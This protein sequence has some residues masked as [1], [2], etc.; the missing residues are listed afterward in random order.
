MRHSSLGK[1]YDW[2][3]IRE[4][5]KRRLPQEMSESEKEKKIEKVYADYVRSGMVPSPVFDVLDCNIEPDYF[6]NDDYVKQLLNNSKRLGKNNK[7]F[8]Q[9]TP[10]VIQQMVS[11]IPM[12]RVDKPKLILVFN[13]TMSPSKWFE[14]YQT[15]TMD[16]ILKKAGI[17]PLEH[18]YINNYDFVKDYYYDA[19]QP[20]A[21]KYINE[22]KKKLQNETW[23][24]YQKFGE[25]NF[26]NIKTYHDIPI[27]NFIKVSYYYRGLLLKRALENRSNIVYEYTHR[28][29]YNLTCLL[30]NNKA[31]LKEYEVEMYFSNWNLEQHKKWMI[32][33]LKQHNI[34]ENPR[35]ITGQ[36][37][38]LLNN[39]VYALD[40][41]STYNMKVGFIDLNT[42]IVSNDPHQVYGEGAISSVV[43]FYFKEL[44][45][46]I[47]P[48]PYSFK[49]DK[50][51]EENLKN[52]HMV[53]NFTLP[54]KYEGS[55]HP[56][57]H[58]FSERMQIASGPDEF[59]K[60]TAESFLN[61]TFNRFISQVKA[62]PVQN[63]K[64]IMLYGPPGV[65][66]SYTIDKFME[67]FGGNCVFIPKDEI[68]EESK[69]YTIELMNA[70]D[71]IYKYKD[72]M[73]QYLGQA[74]AHM[75]LD[76]AYMKIVNSIFRKYYAVIN[77]FY[78]MVI[79]WASK[80]NLNIIIEATGNNY[81]HLTSVFK[82]ASIALYKKEVYA[83]HVNYWENYMNTL[84]RIIKEPIVKLYFQPGTYVGRSRYF[85]RKELLEYNNNSFKNLQRFMT[86]YR[87][88]DIVLADNTDKNIVEIFRR[89][90]GNFTCVNK[91]QE[92]MYTYEEESFIEL[93]KYCGLHGAGYEFSSNWT[94]IIVLFAFI[95]LTY[96][97]VQF[98]ME[99]FIASNNGNFLSGARSVRLMFI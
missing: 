81:E 50:T 85:R 31:I 97:F 20:N 83:I 79:E 7:S 15:N 67:S 70:F 3:E 35:L 45:K 71:A 66:K 29:A 23:E 86:E 14:A 49:Y 58:G 84:T 74:R 1:K 40:I 96:Y 34:M 12:K 22:L 48:A 78:F 55:D 10:R 30:E 47:Q 56:D 13:Q 90:D 76:T 9:S 88:V 26:K 8:T 77:N 4:H 5:V 61:H 36:Q 87:N 46:H 69:H 25:T 32:H 98:F 82:L 80:Q 89:I 91:P 2:N 75:L 95:I 17:I 99:C 37:D 93:M 21:L 54:T 73:I 59:E 33:L 92:Y 41:S 39:I 60:P 52:L 19:I 64:I 42:R 11:R 62:I 44:S 65:G 27:S 51:L 24:S 38:I 63:P 94:F 68:V 16:G 53:Q 6:I 72:K 28:N 18:V 57:V 43:N